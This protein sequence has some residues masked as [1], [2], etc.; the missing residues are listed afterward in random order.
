MLRGLFVSLEIFE[1][2]FSGGISGSVILLDTDASGFMEKN[3]IEFMEEIEFQFSNP[4]G[5]TL[6]FKGFMN[7]I[8]DETIKQQK[9]MYTIDFCSKAVRENDKQFVTKA[10]KNA[11][12]GAIAGEMS[13]LLLTDL[14]QKG[15]RS[16]L[17]M[18]YVASR[19]K[20]LEVMKYVMKHAVTDNSSLS[21]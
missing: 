4:E 7:G 19:K 13:D 18:N 1:S 20:P 15:T 9:K 11:K 21:S 14:V 3:G 10:F 16:G 17:P 12:P 8:R 6:S 2:I 5:R